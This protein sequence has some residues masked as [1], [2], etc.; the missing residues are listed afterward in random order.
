MDDGTFGFLILMWIGASFLVAYVAHEKQ[1]SFFVWLIIGLL[2]S[3]LLGLLAL[4]ALPVATRVPTP[5][6]SGFGGLGTIRNSADEARY[7]R[8]D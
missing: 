1:R 8:L 3:P 7:R 2:F 6:E 5:S 4:A